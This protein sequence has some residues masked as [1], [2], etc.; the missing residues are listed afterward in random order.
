[1]SLQKNRIPPKEMYDLARKKL[2]S[3]NQ[4]VL[5]FLKPVTE[6]NPVTPQ[7]LLNINAD[8]T[9]MELLEKLPDL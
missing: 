2:G 5:W 3:H 4:V 8:F 1:M 9:V 7:H 6:G